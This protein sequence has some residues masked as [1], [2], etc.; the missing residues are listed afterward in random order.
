[1]QLTK[2]QLK[3]SYF[4]FI[5]GKEILAIHLLKLFKEFPQTV[6]NLLRFRTG[7]DATSWKEILV[8]CSQ[9]FFKNNKN[10]TSHLYACIERQIN[11][12]KHWYIS[13]EN[14]LSII[15]PGQNLHFKGTITKQFSTKKKN[16]PNEHLLIFCL[17]PLLPL[18]VLTKFSSATWCVVILCNMNVK[19]ACQLS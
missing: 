12:K 5:S 3:G 1:M 15:K 4:S 2:S 10:K 9:I 19:L 7:M 14:Y 18:T 13:I 17:I 6:P 16:Y 11:I 8:A